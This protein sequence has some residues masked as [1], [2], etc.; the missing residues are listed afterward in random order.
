MPA[1][2]NRRPS[3]GRWGRGGHG[4]RRQ[5]GGCAP[6]QQ[7]VR[8]GGFVLLAVALG[9]A[10]LAGAV[11][12]VPAARVRAEGSAPQQPPSQ[13]ARAAILVDAATG[14]VLYARNAD[15]TMPMAS[16]TK[17]M[18]ALLAIERGDL[19]Q[20]I[21]TSQRAFGVEG[22]SLYLALGEQRTLEELLYGL[23]LQSGNDA[24]VAIAEGLAGSVETFVQWM[25]QRARELGLEHTRFADPHGLASRDHYTSARDLAT[26]ARVALANPT[27][28]RVVGTREYRMPWPEK[29]SERVLY[30]HNR[31]LWHDGATGVKNG[32]TSAARGALVA[33]A[34]RD[35]IELVGVL[36]GAH[37]TGMYR[38][39]AALMDWGF[40]RFEPLPL[41]Q[42]G[43][44]VG[45]VPVR[46]GR[47]DSVA[48]VAAYGARWLVPRDEPAPPVRRQVELEQALQAP[49][50]EGARVGTLV[51]RVGDQVVDRIPL[52]SAAA[53]EPLTAWEAA[54]RAVR[55]RQPW[56]YAWGLALLAAAWAVLRRRRAML[57]RRRW[58]RRV[59]AFDP[60]WYAFRARD[61]GAD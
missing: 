27:F 36:L 49:V 48:A 44:R 59:A 55:A 5:A 23:M 28:R 12:W 58:R 41:V 33:S 43:E 26:L 34:Q 39:M 14:Q 37:P 30:N 61:P 50:G 6:W 2:T 3:A 54:A 10:V 9:L 32:Y 22:S 25:N 51:V 57:A 21:T 52:L 13:D 29:N 18:T 47:Q 15:A 42:A 24:A 56:P 38:D 1:A 60:L 8:R 53:V 19:Q 20:V 11:P 46:G 4:G 40:A 45:Q 7:A 35:G 31:F 16:T 17:I